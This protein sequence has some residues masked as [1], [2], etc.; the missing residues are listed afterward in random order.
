MEQPID[1]IVT[2]DARLNKDTPLSDR[3]D[4]SQRRGLARR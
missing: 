3:G 1:E 2:R 4:R